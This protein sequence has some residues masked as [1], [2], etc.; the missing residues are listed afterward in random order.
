MKMKSNNE[1]NVNGFKRVDFDPLL[2]TG[3]GQS[4]YDESNVK[5]QPA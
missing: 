1:L 4:L 2:G 5:R 3:G